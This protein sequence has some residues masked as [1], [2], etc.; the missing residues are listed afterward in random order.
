MP[1]EKGGGRSRDEKGG[2][3]RGRSELE[4]GRLSMSVSMS[5]GRSVAPLSSRFDAPGSLDVEA[6]EF[7]AD[8]PSEGVLSD[9]NL[10]MAETNGEAV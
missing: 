2:G 5:P 6:S 4:P 8:V 10:A 9:D 1:A 7:G 3:R